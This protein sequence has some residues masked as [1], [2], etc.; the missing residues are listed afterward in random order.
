MLNNKNF[1]ALYHCVCVST[2]WFY[3]SWGQMYSEIK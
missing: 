3:K 1:V 2:D